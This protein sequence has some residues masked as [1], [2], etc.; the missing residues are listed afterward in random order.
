MAKKIISFIVILLAYMALGAAVIISTSNFGLGF[1]ENKTPLRSAFAM[2][3][4]G[5]IYFVSD[6]QEEKSLVCIDSSGKKLYERKLEEEI[7]GESFY[8]DRIYIEHDR[9]IYVTACTF[10]KDTMF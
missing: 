6:N 3:R 5:D 10:N 9:G 4:A 7:F 8:I 2:D 1:G